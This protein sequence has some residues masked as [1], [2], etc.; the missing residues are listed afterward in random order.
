MLSHSKEIVILLT[1]SAFYLIA[2]FEEF[3]DINEID[4]LQGVNRPSPYRIPGTKWCGVG[5][6]AKH[7]HQL[8][9]FHE[10]DKCCRDHDFCD[11]MDRGQAKNGLKNTFMIAKLHC[12]CDKEFRDCLQRI[13]TK[14][15]NTIGRLYFSIQDK[16]Y[17]EAHPIMSCQKK[18]KSWA[19]SRCTKY[20]MDDSQ[21]VR[22]QWFDLPFYF[23]PAEC[24]AF[25]E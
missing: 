25:K 3:S 1:C 24:D 7:Y 21:P 18:T 2:A 11:S 15:A 16:C 12:K 9:R 13:N 4:E 19:R 10:V 5:S 23:E 22:Y 6:I 14:L 17:R 20:Q 8:G